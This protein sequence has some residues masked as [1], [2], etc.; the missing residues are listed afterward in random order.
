M[1][2]IKHLTQIL[3]TATQ[4]QFYIGKSHFKVKFHI[5]VYLAYNNTEVVYTLHPVLFHSL[6]VESIL[7]VTQS[8]YHA[9]YI[10]Q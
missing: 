8:E 7:L 4:V 6:P 5:T 9:K 3:T 1:A 10:H 2:N